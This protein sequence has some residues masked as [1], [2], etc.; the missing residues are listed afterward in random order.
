MRTGIAVSLI[1]A[2]FFGC[3]NA[4]VPDEAAAD[5]ATPVVIADGRAVA[6]WT[7]LSEWMTRAPLPEAIAAA[8]VHWQ[9]QDPS[10]EEEAQIMAAADG[11]F[12]EPGADQQAVLYLMSPW[13]RCCP[14]VGLA[15]IQDGRLVRNV[16]FEGLAQDLQAVAD[17]DGDGRNELVTTGSFGMGGQNTTGITLLSF[18]DGGLTEW[19]GTTT[20][21]DSCAAGMAGGTAARVTAAPGPAFTIER[22]TV[23]S[24]ETPDWQ[25]VGGPE[26]FEFDEQSGVTYVELP[27]S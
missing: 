1:W 26:P 6:E 24:C 11:A 23:A 10:Y 7:D 27:I 9:G 15:V 3:A 25:P 4:Q 18:G 17:L 16:A 22:F 21:D 5:A 14:K 20:S 2:A 12:T 19:G 8:R 13:P